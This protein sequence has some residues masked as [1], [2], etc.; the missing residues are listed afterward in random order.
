MDKTGPTI[1]VNVPYYP[2]NLGKA[3]NDFMGRLGPEEWACFLD[4]DAMFTTGDWYGQMCEIINKH[5]SAGLFTAVTNAVYPKWQCVK[6]GYAHDV[7]KHRMLGSD[8]LLS[9]RTQ[10]KPCRGRLS[11]V[12]ILTSRRAWEKSGGFQDG[13]MGVDNAYHTAVAKAGYDVLLMEGLYV[14]HWYRG[15]E[16]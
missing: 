15:I 8:L 12:V 1:V 3:Y 4:H 9:K 16:T 11:G 2:G 7:K 13:F 6:M 5:P 10:T 14:Y